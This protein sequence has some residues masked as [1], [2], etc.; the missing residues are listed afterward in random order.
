MAL[1]AMQDTPKFGLGHMSLV[2]P[3]IASL[4]VVLDEAMGT[5]A[6][7]PCPQCCINDD[8][9]CRAYNSGSRLGEIGCVCL[10]LSG[11]SSCL[12][13]TVSP[14]GDPDEFSHDFRGAVW[15]SCACSLEELGPGFLYQATIC[16]LH[17]RRSQHLG[18]GG[19][20]RPLQS[21]LMANGMCPGF[22]LLFPL[23]MGSLAGS[24]PRLPT[25]RGPR[26]DIL[27][28]GSGTLHPGSTHPL[29]SSRYVLQFHRHPPI[30]GQ[31]RITTL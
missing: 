2:E 12:V 13:G 28:T 4:I 3:A 30:T 14:D 24:L 5:N 6:R 1:V 27:E 15:F 26:N 25:A 10:P 11:A 16:G 20:C 9:L 31:V 23:G 18:V 29:D 7:C 19:S 8:L 17:R 21:L 22:R